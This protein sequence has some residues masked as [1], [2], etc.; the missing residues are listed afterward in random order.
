VL[1]FFASLLFLVLT[2]LTATQVGGVN[3]WYKPF[4]FALSIALYPA[5][6]LGW[7]L[8]CHHFNKSLFAWAVIVLWDLKLFTYPA[9]SKGTA[10]AFQCQQSIICCAL[11]IDGG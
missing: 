5:Q 1:C 9:S 2:R 3:A 11:W 8:T 4:K 10:I 7:S 6:W